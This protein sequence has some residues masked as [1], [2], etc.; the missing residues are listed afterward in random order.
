[1][2]RRDG[3]GDG[4]DVAERTFFRYFDSKEDL[5]L[6][7]VEALF[8]AITVA[9]RA[10][11]AAEAPLAAVLAAITQVWQRGSA[12]TYLGGLGRFD[13]AGVRRSPRSTVNPEM[14]VRAPAGRQQR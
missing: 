13:R 6:P 12:L 14:P 3:L 9:V 5:L 11:P 10:R 4:A 1:L 7:D 2:F 8:E